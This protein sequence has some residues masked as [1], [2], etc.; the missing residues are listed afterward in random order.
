ML[1]ERGAPGAASATR[2]LGLLLRERGAHAEAASYLAMSFQD[3]P[4]SDPPP[5]R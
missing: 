2:E 3:A 4:V 1:R 5:A